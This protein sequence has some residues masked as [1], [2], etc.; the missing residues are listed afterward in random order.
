MFRS[1]FP[2]SPAYLRQLNAAGRERARALFVF[3]N[4]LILIST[5]FILA[6]NLL[7]K[8][9]P[10]VNV[11]IAAV[12]VSSFLCL[13]LLHNGRP[14]LAGNIINAVVFSVILYLTYL[15]ATG[16][17]P[18]HGFTQTGMM[19]AGLALA[20]LFGSKRLP[21]VFGLIY[22]L[23]LVALVFYLS[24]LHHWSALRR[25]T[26][27]FTLDGIIALAAGS[28]LIFLL[29]RI[30]D[31]S[32]AAI[33]TRNRRLERFLSSLRR[34]EERFHRLSDASFEAVVLS[35]DGRILEANR[36]FTE[37]FGHNADDDV[38]IE[39]LVSAEHRDRL[40]SLLNSDSRKSAELL[41]KR[42][43]GSTLLV[44][45][46]SSIIKNPDSAV[47]SVVMRDITNERKNLEQL[48]HL[49]YHDA[50][51]GLGNRKLL[52]QTTESILVEG[53]RCAILLADL[54]RFK[55]INDTLGHPFG[56]ALLQGLAHR[57][58]ESFPAPFLTCRTGGD[59]FTL[60]IPDPD[61]ESMV[62]DIAQSFSDAINR[63]LRTDG[64]TLEMQCSIGA[65]YSPNHG[66]DFEA[67]FRCADVAMYAAK[68]SG[69]GIAVYASIL[70]LHNPRRLM[71]LSD[72][73]R[74]VRE[75]AFELHFQPKV[76]LINH[77][78]DGYEVLTRWTHPRLGSISPAELIPLAETGNHIGLLTE[79][80]IDVTLEQMRSWTPQ[81][82]PTLAVNVSARNLVDE[83]FPERVIQAIEEYNINPAQ[84]ELEITESAFMHDP[85]RAL[86]S[87]LRLNQ[88]GITLSID[89]FGTGYSSLSYLTDLPVQALK[90]DLSFIREM[91]KKEK[92][93]ILVSSTIQLAHG[94]GL[95]VIAEGVE[96]EDTARALRKMEC[97]FGQGFHFGAPVPAPAIMRR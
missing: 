6:L 18:L 72:L 79:T 10:T 84:L 86:Q 41:C 92:H 74:M 46:R 36:A 85:Q 9:L 52:Q 47:R 37:L 19:A 53:R 43:D 95:A 71:L 81:F 39:G 42:K 69:T 76:D 14:Q 61:G 70:D 63:A 60:L 25:S 87:V 20:G 33:S 5:A 78:I 97:D 58:R 26:V 55:E 30:Y 66:S 35:Q 59:E 62:R 3:L 2:E 17:H 75:R 93:Q 12:I 16:V 91:I 77:D 7:L 83:M 15:D 45:A 56:D 48:E 23:T 1:L 89:D 80:V 96:N 51:T 28:I 21:L 40:R 57:I 32:L 34:S 54:D 67:L 73:G 88:A 31:R 38:T 4:A 27:E 24:S 11:L 49:A 44:E 50:L 82:K 13:W 68:R 29:R 94:L 64:V 8:P 22:S 65:S 90:I